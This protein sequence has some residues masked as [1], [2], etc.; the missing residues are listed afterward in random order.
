MQ[1]INSAVFPH[2]CKAIAAIDGSVRLGLEGNL[3]LA[4]AVGANSGEV[5]LGAS[6]SV[7]SGVAAGLA[8]LGLILEA[9]LSVEFLL[10]GGE[11]EFISALFANQC[12]VFVHCLFFLTFDKNLLPRG[13]YMRSVI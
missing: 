1:S 4:A 3:R 2:L 11:N 6:G 8:A 5:L 9:S 10:A 13:A 12:L 7:L